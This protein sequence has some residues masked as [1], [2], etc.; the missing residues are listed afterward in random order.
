MAPTHIHLAV[1]RADIESYFKRFRIRYVVFE[2]G[3]WT[4][5]ETIATLEKMLSAAPFH[6]IKVVSVAA[7]TP[8]HDHELRIYRYDGPIA[9][10]REPFAFDMPLIGSR[11]SERNK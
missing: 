1:S 2:S 7:N 3:F 6:L 11:F 5:I 10:T 9:A 4:D 8:H